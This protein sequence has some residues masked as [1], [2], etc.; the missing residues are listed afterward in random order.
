MTFTAQEI[1]ALK[2][3]APLYK[4]VRGKSAREK[5]EFFE[6][7]YLIW[8][9]YCPVY[10]PIDM[11]KEEYEWRKKGQ[12]KVFRGVCRIIIRFD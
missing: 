1:R 8:F 2:H 10:R 3:L 5:N 12:L 4:S 11:E 6:Q 7:A 9:D